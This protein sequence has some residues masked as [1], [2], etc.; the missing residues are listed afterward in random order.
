MTNTKKHCPSNWTEEYICLCD[1]KFGSSQTDTLTNRRPPHLPWNVVV[2]LPL[3]Q[4]IHNHRWLY[5]IV[6]QGQHPAF[7]TK[8]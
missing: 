7:K 6:Q 4:F 8:S 3:V 1:A 5:V 2:K